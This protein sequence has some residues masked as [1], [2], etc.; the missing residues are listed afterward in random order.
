MKCLR[1]AKPYAVLSLPDKLLLS[2]PVLMFCPI[3]CAA[4]LTTALNKNRIEK[5]FVLEATDVLVLLAKKQN[6]LGY[7]SPTEIDSYDELLRAQ[8]RV[9]AFYQYDNNSLIG[10]SFQKSV[11]EIIGVSPEPRILSESEVHKLSGF[12]EKIR[13]LPCNPAEMILALRHFMP[14]LKKMALVDRQPR[15]IYEL[16]EILLYWFSRFA[17][18]VGLDPMPESITSLW[19]PC[20]VLYSGQKYLNRLPSTF[21]GKY[22]L[23]NLSIIPEE[24]ID[25][26]EFE[27]FLRA[28]VSSGLSMN[29]LCMNFTKHFS[30]E[31]EAHKLCSGC[32]MVRYCSEECQKEDWK[33]H[34]KYCKRFPNASEIEHFLVSFSFP[35][36]MKSVAVWA[37]LVLQ[38]PWEEVSKA[39]QSRFPNLGH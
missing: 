6:Q 25:K 15:T 33:S 16:L 24:T 2:F 32:K 26:E 14:H 10:S 19:A 17:I 1:A 4:R 3:K 8:E 31:K 29:K 36:L 38:D 7:E 9:R 22:C 11:L 28:N 21:I 27:I 12:S 23:Q 20:I 39:I 13:P 37:D 18:S 5:T 35:D 34:K 30:V